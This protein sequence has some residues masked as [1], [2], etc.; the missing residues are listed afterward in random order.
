MSKTTKN[1]NTLKQMN[2]RQ[3]E[4][5]SV[6]DKKIKDLET[7]LT[8]T[9]SDFYVT[10]VKVEKLERENKD[11]VTVFGEVNR[12]LN[13]MRKNFN[14]HLAA[15]RNERQHLQSKISNLF[16]DKARL[17]SQIDSQNQNGCN[18]SEKLSA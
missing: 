6:R 15:F 18:V 5:I 10:A 11:A 7:Q 8:K 14:D 2:Q 9:S 4:M 1:P 12:E 13:F 3:A 16:L 17:Q